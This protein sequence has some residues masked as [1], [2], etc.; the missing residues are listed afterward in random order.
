[1]KGI[2]TTIIVIIAI[3]NYVQTDQGCDKNN[4]NRGIHS[5]YIED[6]I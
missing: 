5:E 2:S 1:L 3:I 6:Y 4:H